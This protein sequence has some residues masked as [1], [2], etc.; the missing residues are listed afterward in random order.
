M[1]H[2][3]VDMYHQVVDRSTGFTV[4]GAVWVDLDASNCGVLD[5]MTNPDA[6]Q[7]VTA[8]HFPGGLALTTR[9]HVSGD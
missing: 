8:H 5:R 2:T 6:K 4:H 7:T 1:D 9:H 3:E